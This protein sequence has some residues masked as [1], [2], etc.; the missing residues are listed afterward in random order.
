MSDYW[1]DELGEAQLQDVSFPLASRAFAGGYDG[2]RIKRPYRDGQEIDRTGRKPLVFNLVIPLFRGVDTTHYPDVYL[3]LL[4][5][6]TADDPPLEYTDPILGT[7][8]VE[9]ESFAID[10]DA[11]KREGATVKVTL[12]E[13]TS[14]DFSAI[15][16]VRSPG[17][18][19]IAWAAE[20]DTE[21]AE[22]GVSDE[23]VRNAFDGAGAPVGQQ[24]ALGSGSAFRDMASALAEGLTLGATVASEVERAV[25]TVRVRTMAVL[26]V[27]ELATSGGF[28]ARA[29]GY[30]MLE[31]VA[32]QGERAIARSAPLIDRVLSGAVGARELSVELY[33]TGDRAG[34]IVRRNSSRRPWGFTP[35][36]RVRVAIR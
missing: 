19:A 8:Q 9:V 28:G 20:L 29:A 3:E 2:A 17:R 6:L 16:E 31:S 24:E 33:G 12:E 26:G 5:V 11:E 21:L 18:A 25:D 7:F 36:T 22:A 4:D 10:E 23:V 15:V 32:A 1:E 13:V 30:L 34:E 27:A 14:A 35:G